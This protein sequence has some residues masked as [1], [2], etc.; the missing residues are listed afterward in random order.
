MNTKLRLC[1]MYVVPVL[2]YGCETYSTT[3]YLCD[4]IDSYDMWAIR[5]SSY[6]TLHP[7]CDQ[8]WSLTHLWLP[9]SLSH[10]NR[11]KIAPLWRHHP[12]FT[13]EDHYHSVASAIQKPPSDWKRPKGR[14]SHTWLRAIETDLKP[15]NIGL[16]SAWKKAT[17]QETWRSGWT[18]QRSRRVRHEKEKKRMRQEPSSDN[19][20]PY[21]MNDNI[22]SNGVEWALGATVETRC[23]CCYLVYVWLTTWYQI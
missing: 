1:Q 20:T 8:N 10:H 6:R 14:P 4:R 22:V 7:S 3:K 9:A 5:S 18:R 17:S 19:T 13:N 2:L 21:E 12:Q 15:V 23:M 16:S 11:Q